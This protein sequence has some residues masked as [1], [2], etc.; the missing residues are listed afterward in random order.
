VSP[1]RWY[2]C[3]PGTPFLPFPHLYGSSNWQTDGVIDLGP[4]ERWD[5][6]RPYSK[7]QLPG[8]QPPVG[9]FCG[10]TDWWQNG[11]PSDAPPLDVNLLG[12]PLCCV[13]AGGLLLGGYS[14]VRTYPPNT[15]G[16]YLGGTSELSV[17]P[18]SAG[19]LLL[20]GS[21]NVYLIGGGLLI[22]GISA[23]Q[24]RYA[25]SGGLLVGGTSRVGL[26]ARSLGGLLVG[27]TSRAGLLVADRGGLLLGGTSTAK[28]TAAVSGGVKVGGTSAIYLPCQPYVYTGTNTVLV[29]DTVQMQY[30]TLTTFFP[31]SFITQNPIAPGAHVVGGIVGGSNCQGYRTTLINLLTSGPLNFVSYDAIANVGTWQVPLTSSLYPGRVFTVTF[32]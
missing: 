1:V 9:E 24:L 12:Q 27:G 6:L 18:A 10:P 32:T 3:P 8:P 26:D 28:L 14:S 20:G 15:G 5:S 22:G 29:Y 2:F 4:G 16:L 17:S 30:W 23:S 21:S 13:A 19:G 11:V 7:G 31:A 25:G